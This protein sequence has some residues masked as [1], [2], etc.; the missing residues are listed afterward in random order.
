VTRS[1]G[2]RGAQHRKPAGPAGAS[3]LRLGQR[4]LPP[5]QGSSPA[6][7]PFGGLAQRARP[8]PGSPPASP[9]AARAHRR[10]I[11]ELG[12][13]RPRSLAHK[14]KAGVAGAE[15][16]LSRTVNWRRRRSCSTRMGQPCSSAP[17]G[18]A[19]PECAIARAAALDAARGD[20]RRERRRDTAWRPQA[21]AQKL[22]P[23]GGG[24]T[25][26]WGGGRAG[27]QL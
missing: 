16:P 15:L 5:L 13:G 19:A 18:T 23:G 17:R 12:R 14:Q 1:S 11:P 25:K 24:A 7:R 26:R 2:L 22:T 21:A 3:R 6:R 10:P 9:R 27:N 4:T 8:V 20:R